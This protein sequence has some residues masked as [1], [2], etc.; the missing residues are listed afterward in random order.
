MN[1]IKWNSNVMLKQKHNRNCN[2]N[3]HMPKRRVSLAGFCAGIFISFNPSHRLVTWP[4][5]EINLLMKC[6]CISVITCVLCSFA[7]EIN[8]NC[9]ENRGTLGL[10]GQLWTW[11]VHTRR[12]HPLHS[13]YSQG[14]FWLFIFILNFSF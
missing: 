2:Q 3:E 5:G 1:L 14:F 10:K 8:W 12:L 7:F 4:K 9:S 11:L 6:F 13:L